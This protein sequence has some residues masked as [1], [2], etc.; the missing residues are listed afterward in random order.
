[1]ARNES[2]FR[3]DAE[4]GKIGENLCFEYLKKSKYSQ[5]EPICVV[6]NEFFQD[7]DVDFV[8][9]TEKGK[10]IDDVIAYIQESGKKQI[11]FAYLF[12][13]KTDTRGLSSGN[14]YLEIT[15]GSKIGF[16]LKSFADFWYVV[17]VDENNIPKEGYIINYKK[18]FSFVMEKIPYIEKR[19]CKYIKD[20]KEV[21]NSKGYTIDYLWANMF[22]D[23]KHKRNMDIYFYLPYFVE[24]GIAKKIFAYA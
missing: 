11:P 21:K 5:E 12:E 6:D 18:L 7:R 4:F 14:F 2:N 9:I 1:M 16:A 15:S 23:D 22:E 19:Q 3:T 20:G 10:T 17:F 13:A 8:Q 24:N